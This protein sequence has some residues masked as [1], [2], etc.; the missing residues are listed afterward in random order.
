VTPSLDVVGAMTLLWGVT[1]TLTT[2]H[3]ISE[4]EQLLIERRLVRRGSLVVFVNISVELDRADANFI[5]V[6]RFS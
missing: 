6:Q 1:P 3:E 2:A 4:I 5:N